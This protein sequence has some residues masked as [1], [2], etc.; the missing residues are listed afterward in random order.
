[1]S[2]ASAT[3]EPTPLEPQPTFPVRK[4]DTNATWGSALLCM[5]GCYSCCC[6]FPA[7]A[8]LVN[9]ISGYAIP[10]A[11]RHLQPNASM[12][13]QLACCIFCPCIENICWSIALVREDLREVYGIS[14]ACPDCAYC[15]CAWRIYGKEARKD[16]RGFSCCLACWCCWGCVIDQLNRKIASSPP[17]RQQW[18]EFVAFRDAMQQYYVA[19]STTNFDG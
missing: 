13:R 2:T 14:N 10:A 18:L 15:Y 11:Q 1:M 16:N 5:D 3:E 4:L 6:A 9:R 12:C 7:L 19:H 8:D 17:T